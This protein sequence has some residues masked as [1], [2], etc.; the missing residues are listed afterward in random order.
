[1]SSFPVLGSSPQSYDFLNMTVNI[2]ATRF[3]ISFRTRGLIW[4]GP[5]ALWTFR[6]CSSF[7]TPD[8]VISMS[9][10]SG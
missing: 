2:G 4:S 10:M 1:M 5:A 6:C 3:A 7:S 8:S 9:A